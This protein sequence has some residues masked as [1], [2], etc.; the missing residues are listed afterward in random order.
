MDVIIRNIDVLDGRGSPFYR[1]DVGLEGD[2]Y[3]PPASLQNLL[4]KMPQAPITRRH[5][6]AVDMDESRLHHL[7]WARDG[8]PIA[9][10]IR[11]WVDEN[12]R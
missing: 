5:F 11:S 10:T 2:R 7:R 6:T 8:G 12:L 9:A 1:A 3:A 4:D